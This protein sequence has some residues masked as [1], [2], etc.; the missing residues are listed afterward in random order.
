MAVNSIFTTIVKK[1]LKEEME[2]FGILS[3]RNI[4]RIPELI[5]LKKIFKLRFVR[6]FRN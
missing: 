5:L 4:T 2:I 6:I 1:L 3:I